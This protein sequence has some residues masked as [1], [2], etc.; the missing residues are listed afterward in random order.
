MLPLRKD[1]F[2]KF[3]SRQHMDIK[4]GGVMSTGSFK[5]EFM[6]CTDFMKRIDSVGV[7]YT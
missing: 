1:R 2:I 7:C 4:E 6:Q 3:V 5:T